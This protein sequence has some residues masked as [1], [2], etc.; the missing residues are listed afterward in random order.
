M[1]TLNLALALSCAAACASAPVSQA[2]DTTAGLKPSSEGR[3]LLWEV[4]RPGPSK[5]LYLTGSIHVAQPGQ[6][7][8]P[9]SLEA[10]CARSDALVVELDP[11]QVDRRAV[12]ALVLK[13]GLF[14]HRRRGSRRI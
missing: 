7:K 3:A 5:R 1:R 6:L 14:T 10:A 2:H 9:P 11:E 12:Q 8:L 4:R 13:L